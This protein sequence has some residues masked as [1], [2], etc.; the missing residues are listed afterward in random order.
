MKRRTAL[1]LALSSVASRARAA[2]PIKIGALLSYSG[3]FA[4]IGDE[5]TNAMQLAFDHAGGTVAGRPITIVRADTEV[6]PNVALTK[7][8]ELVGSDRVDLLVG[9][10][11]SSESIPLRDF[12]HQRRI[13]LI[14]PHAALDNLFGERC[15][16]YILRTSFSGNQFGRPM[17]AWLAQRGVRTIT[18][19]APDYVGPRDLMEKF[20]AEFTRQG[21]QIVG[22]EFTPFQRTHDFGPYLARVKQQRPDATWVS[23]G[24]AE[25]I[26][27]VR[28]AADFRLS[29]AT[30]V[31]GSGWTVS[32]LVLPAQGDAALGFQGLL[33]YAPSIDTPENRRFQ[34]DYRSRHGRTASEFGAQGYDTG[35]F[36][37]AALRALDG[38]TDDKLALARAIRDARIVG[39]R[40]PARIDPATNNIVQNMYIVEVRRGSNG[41]ELAVLDTMPAVTDE[42]NGCQMRLEG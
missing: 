7:A 30:R 10:V 19:M 40:G 41:P 13:P 28:Q 39:A 12:A 11:S 6:R 15:S 38:R 22:R 8:R 32:P 29:E 9:P 18:L 14:M 27:F 4:S 36:I 37:A 35:L 17:A 21:G 2:E 34:A 26:N 3:V 16:P 31:T 24:G 5:I 25:A 23:Y 42:P 20:E 33:N 1:T